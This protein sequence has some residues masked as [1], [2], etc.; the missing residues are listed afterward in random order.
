M[1]M[2]PMGSNPYKKS[3]AKQI[4]KGYN[5]LKMGAGIFGL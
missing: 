5:L 3:P 4:Q 1:V 2:N